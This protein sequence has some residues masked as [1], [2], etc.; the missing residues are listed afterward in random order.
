MPRPTGY[1]QPMSSL[2]ER[3]DAV[4][5]RVHEAAECSG[6]DPD[7]IR[8]V[9]ASK[10]Q[11]PAALSEL[12]NRGHW[13]FGENRVQEGLPKIEAVADPRVEWHFLGPLQRNKARF[14]PGRFHWLHSLD[15]LAVAE[16]LARHISAPGQELRVL[17]EVNVTGDPRKHG[18]SPAQL[19]PFLEAYCARS[20][21]GL[22]LSGLMTIGPKDAPPAAIQRCFAGLRGLSEGARDRFGLRSFAELSMGMSDDYPLAIAEGATIVRVGRALFGERSQGLG[23]VGA[24]HGGA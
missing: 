3:L 10:G 5:Q 7:S 12:V 6:R 17:V 11:A 1:T 22:I 13:R 20:W 15:H 21:P 18:L 14:L 16:A 9:A 2:A 24:D 19:F 8:L 4:L 23:V